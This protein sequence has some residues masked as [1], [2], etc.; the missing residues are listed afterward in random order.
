MENKVRLSRSATRTGE[1]DRA[2][3]TRSGV[4]IWRR[5]RNQ[6]LTGHLNVE[7]CA[8]LRCHQIKL[9]VLFPQ[10]LTR[11]HVPWGIHPCPDLGQIMYRNTEFHETELLKFR[12]TDLC[13]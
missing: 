12:N 9:N 8:K 10:G 11:W 1:P 6:G 5:G 3:L 4:A 13:Q 2:A 7:V